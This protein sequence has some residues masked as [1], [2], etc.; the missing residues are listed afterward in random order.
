MGK[1]SAD[2]VE[3]LAQSAEESS[4]SVLQMAATN[5]EVA[6]NIQSRMALWD[7]GFEHTLES[8]I[9]YTSPYSGRQATFVVLGFS[10]DNWRNLRF[11][12]K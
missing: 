9:P 10:R 2:N 11:R 12:N 5:N 4:S 8:A 3:V 7:I 6:E 1:S